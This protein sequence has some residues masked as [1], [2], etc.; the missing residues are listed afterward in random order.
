MR[1]ALEIVGFP[2]PSF[3]Q[4]ITEVYLY[5]PAIFKWLKGMLAGGY[6]IASQRHDQRHKIA[7]YRTK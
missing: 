3:N 2:A 5:V 4:R 6:G 7:N 1:P